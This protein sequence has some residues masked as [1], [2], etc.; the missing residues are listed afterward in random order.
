MKVPFYCFES[1]K[2]HVYNE[3]TNVWL[4]CLL[5]CAA[6]CLKP[7]EMGRGSQEQCCADGVPGSELLVTGP[8]F[9]D[10]MRVTSHQDSRWRQAGPGAP[11][12][13][14]DQLVFSKRT[15]GFRV[16]P[17]GPR[18]AHD[19]GAL[20]AFSLGPAAAPTK[21]RPRGT[22]RSPPLL[23]KASGGSDVAKVTQII[24]EEP[25][26]EPWPPDSSRSPSPH[27]LATVCSWSCQHRDAPLHSRCE[28]AL[29]GQSQIWV[30]TRLF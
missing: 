10:P 4:C 18:A 15:E 16:S 5:V 11:A 6:V 26:L 17:V 20:G 2:Q 23:L 8:E 9:E 12:A 22:Q 25:R 29:L 24:S 1:Q 13:C 28:P 27:P 3:V 21:A 19:K 30:S 14:W 7:V